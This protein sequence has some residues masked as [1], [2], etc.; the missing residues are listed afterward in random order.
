MKIKSATVIKNKENDKVYLE[1]DD[2]PSP[3]PGKLDNHWLTMSFEAS[4]GHGKDYV[5]KNFHIEPSIIDL[6]GF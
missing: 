5:K 1:I 2:C 3:H 4:P 6:T